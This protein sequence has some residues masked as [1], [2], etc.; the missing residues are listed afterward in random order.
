MPGMVHFDIQI[1]HYNLGEP[2]S[3]T[4]AGDNGKDK[5]HGCACAIAL[6]FDF[7]CHSYKSGECRS[8]ILTDTQ[9][10]LPIRPLG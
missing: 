8:H 4:K 5:L 6:G 3:Q 2:M 10:L 7:F 9:W 1:V